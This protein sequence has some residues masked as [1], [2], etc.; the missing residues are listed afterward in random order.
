MWMQIRYFWLLEIKSA[1]SKLQKANCVDLTTW[2]PQKEYRSYNIS[3]WNKVMKLI[4]LILKQAALDNLKMNCLYSLAFFFF[5]FFFFF[6]VFF[7]FFFFFFCCWCFFLFCFIYLS[8]ST[9][10]CL[11]FWAYCLLILSPRS[12]SRLFLRRSSK[13]DAVW[14]K[15]SLGTLQLTNYEANSAYSMIGLLIC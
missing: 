15:L 1:E 8:F 6:L 11:T 14:S 2:V 4:K 13:T 10:V 3:I 12:T 9:L 7:F 5:F